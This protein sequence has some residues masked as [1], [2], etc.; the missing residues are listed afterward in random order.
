MMLLLNSAK[1]FLKR[2]IGYI[3][4]QDERLIIGIAFH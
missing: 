2:V 1:D 3:E 4:M